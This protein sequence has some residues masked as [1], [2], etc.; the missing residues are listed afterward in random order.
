VNFHYSDGDV[1]DFV[2]RVSNVSVS[3][4]EG[5]DVRQVLFLQGYERSPVRNIRISNCRFEGVKEAD[6][7]EHVE[8]LVLDDVYS[9][10]DS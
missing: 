8:G 9:D 4:V 2:P 1:G 6:V 5:A 10:F 3:D 7:V